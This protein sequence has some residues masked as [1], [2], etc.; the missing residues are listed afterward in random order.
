M[1]DVL[2]SAQALRNRDV[3]FPF[4]GGVDSGLFL[5]GSE[6]TPAAAG[7]RKSVVGKEMMADRRGF[8]M[9]CLGKGREKMKRQTNNG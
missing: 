7:C 6:T 4:F 2:P 9:G 8:V 5:V 3:L 1:A